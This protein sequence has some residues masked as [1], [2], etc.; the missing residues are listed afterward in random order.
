MHCQPQDILDWLEAHP[1]LAGW[2]SGLGTILG[3]LGATGIALYQN[4]AARKAV[5]QAGR[6]VLNN[7]QKA[8]AEVLSVVAN[9][10][11]MIS[12]AL[13]D[14]EILGQLAQIRSPEY[15][16]PALAETLKGLPIGELQD[17]E[18]SGAVVLAQSHVY[19][20]FAEFQDLR[21]FLRRGGDLKAQTS[22]DSLAEIAASSEALNH[23]ARRAKVIVAAN[24]AP[25]PVHD[26]E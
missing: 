1:G 25:N 3:I 2:A 17:E 26:I 11:G 4:R 20:A 13:K 15:V 6:D 10:V 9:R 14:Q 7:K 24:V 19:H 23:Q 21:E 5:E 22:I 12:K 8:V 16:L 18:L